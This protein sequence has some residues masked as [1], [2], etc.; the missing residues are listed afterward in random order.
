MTLVDFLS[1]V[2]RNVRVG[3]MLARE[4]VRRRMESSEGINFSEFTYQLLQ[5]YDFWHLYNAKG[6]TV[7]IG[8]NDQFGNI[9]AGMD[10]IG[11]LAQQQQDVAATGEQKPAFGLTVPILTTASGE[12]FGKSAGN[13]IFL[14]VTP[15]ELYQYF[16]KLEDGIVDKFLRAFTL[17][18]LDEIVEIVDAHMKNPDAR[19]G[20]KKAAYEITAL[21]HGDREAGKAERQTALLFPSSEADV[22]NVTARDIL[23]AFEGS[24]FIKQ[25]PREDVV[26]KLPSQIV[27]ATG[28]MS[29]SQVDNLIKQGGVYIGFDRR[30]KVEAALSPAQEDWLMDD[31]VLVLRLGKGKTVVIELI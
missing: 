23:D 16:Y 25:L 19:L 29:R 17:L 3:Q 18:P 20:Q 12:K 8:G 14:D 26:G 9:T 6:C 4:S 5:S 13:A 7:Q 30:K 21:L 15:F 2:G 31:K 1:T 11:R 28:V 27:R 22:A 24:D 10:L